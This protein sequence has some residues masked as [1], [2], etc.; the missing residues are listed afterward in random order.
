MIDYEPHEV[1]QMQQGAIDDY[2]KLAERL[3]KRNQELESRIK[4]LSLIIYCISGAICGFSISSML[5]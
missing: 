4:G 5:F 2:A 1:I 3:I